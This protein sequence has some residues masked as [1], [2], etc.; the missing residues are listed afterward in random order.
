MMMPHPTHP[1]NCETCNKKYTERCQ[2]DYSNT[3]GNSD[4]FEGMWVQVYSCG[5]ASHS[6]AP[7]EREIRE[8]IYDEL[9]IIH[10]EDAKRLGEHLVSSPALPQETKDLIR[11]V[12]KDLSGKRG[13]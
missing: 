2:R 8:R 10:G 3:H 7:N 13:K 12:I 5:C 9:G 4:K 6:S 11:G 1:L